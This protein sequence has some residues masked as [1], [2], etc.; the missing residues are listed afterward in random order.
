MVSLVKRHVALKITDVLKKLSIVNSND[1]KIHEKINHFTKI[2]R[3]DKNSSEFGIFSINLKDL[4][5]AFL[6]KSDK[7][8]PEL[9]AIFHGISD[10]LIESCKLENSKLLIKMNLRH[11]KESTLRSLYLQRSLYG[12][13]L[14]NEQIYPKIS[15]K[16]QY[17]WI[18][19]KQCINT[20]IEFSSP[21]IAK[22]LHAG[23]MRS[24]F[25][26]NFL[27]IIHEKF[28]HNVTKINYLGDWGTQYG[29]LAVGFKKFGSYDKLKESPIRHLL[30]VYVKANADESIKIEALAYFTQMEAMDKDSIK[31]WEMFKDLSVRDLE[32]VYKKLD[33]K[34]DF[35]EYESQYYLQAKEVVANL[36]KAGVAYKLENEAIQVKLKKHQ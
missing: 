30:E 5:Q 32:S 1:I 13:E 20:V 22:P 24:T 6:I 12:F 21:N 9:N 11:F 7:L 35:F 14:D 33:I 17:E 3:V 8:N 29:I 23:H 4:E 26:G 18:P 19:K 10:E 27:S 2:K 28:G 36:L 16:T 31:M 34:Y 25:L 15:N